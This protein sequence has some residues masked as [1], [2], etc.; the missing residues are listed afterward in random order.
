MKKPYVWLVLAAAMLILAQFSLTPAWADSTQTLPKGR[1]SVSLSYFQDYVT[2]EFD[3]AGQDRELGYYFN[4]VDVTAIGTP[5]FNA[6]FAL[7]PG[8]PSLYLALLTEKSRVD[9]NAAVFAYSFGVTDNLTFGV[10]FPYIIR[11]DTK[12]DFHALAWPNTSLGL[13]A[14]P[15]DMTFY[16]QQF[17]KRNLGYDTVRSWSGGPGIG[18]IQ[19]GLK[20]R[21]PVNEVI[22]FAVG[23]WGVI[24]TGRVDDERNLT[25][26]GYGNGHTDLGLSAMTDITPVKFVTLNLTGRYSYSFPY[27]RAIFVIDPSNP[28]S[29]YELATKHESGSYDQGDWYEGETEL[30]FHLAQGLNVFTGYTYRQ[31]WG[32]RLDGKAVPLTETIAR[33]AWYGLSADTTQAY[34][35]KNAKLPMVI[36]LYSQPVQTGKKTAKTNR[37][38]V[39]VQVFF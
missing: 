9:M 32:D 39:S 19:L 7:P 35:D 34:L 28:L 38:F 2:R 26:I 23:G 12:V 24:P 8:T 16:A 5:I 18:D 4:N 20:Y 1:S 21:I 22:Q 33:T 15:L 3:S 10:G 37:A 31:G 27:D 25:D 36:S 11:A 29:K 17:L 6:L 13:P 14:G 30:T